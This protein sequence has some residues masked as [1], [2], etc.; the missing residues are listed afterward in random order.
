MDN[1]ALR[2]VFINLHAKVTKDVNPDSVID[3]LLSKKIIST[4]DYHELRQFQGSRNRCRELL[5]L[6]YR[7]SHPRAFIELRLALIY[8]YSW[9]VDEIDEQLTSTTVQHLQVHQT[10]STCRDGEFV[11]VAYSFVNDL[12]Y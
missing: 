6:L 11:L 5:S 7:S 12:L 1:E 4:D 9:I 2:E 3:T 10:H 8:E